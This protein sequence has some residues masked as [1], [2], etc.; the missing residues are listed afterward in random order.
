MIRNYALFSVGYTTRP[1]LR[2]MKRMSELLEM[3]FYN[4]THMQFVLSLGS[5]IRNYIQSHD[6]DVLY[7]QGKIYKSRIY[8]FSK[9]L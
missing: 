4:V 6:E 5:V 3:P 8:S 7:S 1:S 2:V 9:I